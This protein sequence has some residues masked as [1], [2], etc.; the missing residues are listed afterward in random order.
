MFFCPTKQIPFYLL[1]TLVTA[2][3]IHLIF[4]SLHSDN[5]KHTINSS[6]TAIM[7]SLL[8]I[9][10]TAIMLLSSVMAF[11]HQ[12]RLAESEPWHITH[13]F[14]FTATPSSQNNQIVF[15]LFDNN[16]GMQAD[17]VCSRSVPGSVEDATNFYPCANDDFN[18]RWDGTTLRI[19]RFYADPA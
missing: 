5:V 8:S 19:Q 1:N 17:T 16:T 10:T 12:K 14:V 6:N 11:S 15:N 13:L 18:F 4:L 3:R 9:L 2:F 7:H